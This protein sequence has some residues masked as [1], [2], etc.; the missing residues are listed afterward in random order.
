LLQCLP[1][2]F[3]GTHGT[4]EE[5]ETFRAR[6]LKIQ[7]SPTKI[8]TPDGQLMGSTPIEVECLSGAIDILTL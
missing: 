5:V 3:T 4:M 8:L 2:V 1:K 7:T 6:H